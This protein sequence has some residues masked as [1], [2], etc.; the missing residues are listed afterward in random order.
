MAKQSTC[1]TSIARDENLNA[2]GG[3]RLPDLALGPN[4]YIATDVDDFIWVG[5]TVDLACEPLA[6]G[7][8]RFDN[9]DAYVTRFV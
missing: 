6:D 2:A 9:H 7:S 8:V 3:I 5:A 1:P 4:Q